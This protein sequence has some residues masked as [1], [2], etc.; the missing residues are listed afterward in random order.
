MDEGAASHNAND[1]MMLREQLKR[2]EE[3]TVIANKSVI[4]ADKERDKLHK[5]GFRVDKDDLIKYQLRRY[6]L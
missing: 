4:Q 2:S 5:L 3:R 6:Q 1:V